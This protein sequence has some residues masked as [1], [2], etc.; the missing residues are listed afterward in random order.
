MRLVCITIVTNPAIS[1]KP[2][3]LIIGAQKCA[4]S[5]LNTHLGRHPQVCMPEEKDVELFSY[6]VNCNLKMYEAWLQRF[7]SGPGVTRAGDANAAYF[8]TETSSQ[9]GAKPEGFNKQIPE[10]IQAFM[11]NDLQ[12]IVSLR[13]P[14][15]RAVSAYLHHIVHGAIH[16]G[17]TLFDVIKPLG[18]V[19]MG[20]FGA[21]LR[22]W[23]HVFPSAQFLL[24]DDLPSDRVSAER[25]FSSCLTFLGLESL[26]AS[27]QLQD[28]VFAG[29]PRLYLEDGVW[30]SEE[31]PT[32]ADHLPMSR[33]VPRVVVEGTPYLRLIDATELQRLED[34]FADDQDLLKRQ[35]DSSDLRLVESTTGPGR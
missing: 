28:P 18:I 9:W 35:L 6:T 14:A 23:L 2:D 11:G 3:F 22:N 27:E 8:W 33:Q 10:T 30:V 25:V 7:E 32:I 21:H 24:I 12:F 16:P 17:Q 1:M 20:F 4:T 29:M 13:P 34:I 26:T 15:Q 31:H 5:W 19:D